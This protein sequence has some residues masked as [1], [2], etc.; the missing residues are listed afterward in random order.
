LLDNILENALG[1]DLTDKY[2]LATRK[3]CLREKAL[4]CKRGDTKNAGVCY[5]DC[6][7]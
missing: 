7:P 3:G 6:N 2:G 4:N 1:L 5:A